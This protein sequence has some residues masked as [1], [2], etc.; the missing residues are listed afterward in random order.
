V[1]LPPG[2]TNAKA[3]AVTAEALE[4]RIPR[5]FARPIERDE[6]EIG[7]VLGDLYRPAGDADPVVLL[8]GAAP[9]GR[10][11][12]RLVRVAA[13]LARADRAVFVP[14]L[15][16]YG[17]V[18]AEEDIARIVAAVEALHSSSGGRPVVLVGISFGGSL[19][20]IAAAD[21][22][23]RG[24]VATVATFGAYTHLIGLVQAVTTGMSVVADEVIDWDPVPE[25][26]EVL[27]ERIVELLDEDEREPLEQ[28][29][30]GHRDP[31]DLSG[32]AER[33]HALLTNDDPHR[34]FAIAAELPAPIRARIARLSPE[35]HLSEVDADILVAHAR[36]DPVVPYG[37]AVRLSATRPDVDV[38]TLGSFDHVGIDATSPRAWVRAL[39]DLGRIWRF[40]AGVLA[41][42]EGVVPRR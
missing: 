16:L 18:L 5:P 1:V 7:G 41:P 38:R 24:R 22:R 34:T 8:P 3:L 28:V 40:T 26:E 13:A 25:A 36:D 39:G 11:D 12:T 30:A 15:E 19:A 32:G 20:L 33:L 21:E 27:Y 6:V 10:D 4:L 17:E 14:E 23:A 37:E 42:H 35:P 29:L 31:E 2:R 9:R